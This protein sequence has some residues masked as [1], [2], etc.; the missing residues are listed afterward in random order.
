MRLTPDEITTLEQK[1]FPEPIEFPLWGFHM[2]HL[3]RQWAITRG[4]TC[5]E[6]REYIVQCNIFTVAKLV[7]MDALPVSAAEL[8]GGN[9]A[10]GWYTRPP[11]WLL[12]KMEGFADSVE[13]SHQYPC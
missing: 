9:H 2:E 3:P 8:Y 7:Q 4:R 10:P 12:L 11:V 6:A 5:E 13:L 1:H